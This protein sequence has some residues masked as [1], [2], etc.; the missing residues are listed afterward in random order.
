M[1]SGTHF[2]EQNV[3]LLF[4]VVLTKHVWPYFQFRFPKTSSERVSSRQEWPCMKCTLLNSSLRT[5]C[6]LCDMSRQVGFLNVDHCGLSLNKAAN[7]SIK[8]SKHQLNIVKANSFLDVHHQEGSSSPFKSR[9]IPTEVTSLREV[10]VAA[11][12]VTW[13][14][15]YPSSLP[16]TNAAWYLLTPTRHK[17]TK[18]SA[19]SQI[20]MMSII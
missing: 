11:T 18:I 4:T 2:T 7:E 20:M 5:E 1:R 12:V 16:A 14:I 6:G 10:H 9:T 8:N 3:L 17:N 19:L 15:T 13:T